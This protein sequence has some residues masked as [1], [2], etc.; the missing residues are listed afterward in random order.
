[1]S[2]PFN[3]VFLLKIID[4]T[5]SS[6][7]TDSKHYHVMTWSLDAAKRIYFSS[8][9]KF[10]SFYFSIY[11]AISIETRQFLW[12]VDIIFRLLVVT[13]VDHIIVVRVGLYSRRCRLHSLI[14]I[15]TILVA[16]WWLFICDIWSG[17]QMFVS[18]RR[19]TE[20][21]ISSGEG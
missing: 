19:I 14:W 17:K 2:D 21:L 6:N 13:H 3:G 20:R 8:R 18:R 4:C 7:P 9:A 15:Q 1:M 12:F 5:W 11:F 16:K 10:T